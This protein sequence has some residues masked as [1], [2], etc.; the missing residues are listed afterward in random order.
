MH[1]AGYYNLSTP[2]STSSRAT[3]R[4]ASENSTKSSSSENAQPERRRSTFAKIIDQL[5]PLE[6]PITVEGVWSP[7][8]VKKEK[9]S[10]SSKKEG[11]K[12]P[13]KMEKRMGKAQYELISA[14]A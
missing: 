4:R 12:E 2:S 14:A 10:R 6:E 13:L 7:T 9:K 1:Y 3:S 11:K 8:F 5:K